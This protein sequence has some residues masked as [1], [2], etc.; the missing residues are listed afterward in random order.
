MEPC[1]GIANSGFHRYIYGIMAL[2]PLRYVDVTQ[3]DHEGQA[4]VCLRDPEGIVDEPVLLSPAGFFIASQLDGE[5]ESADIQRAFA[6][7]TGGR[8][9]RDGDV[10]HVVSFLDDHGFLLTPSFLE[11]R[12]AV[13]KTFRDSDTRAA[14]LAG[15]SYPA[16]PVELRAYLNDMFTREKGPGEAP[17]SP[18]LDGAPLR[19]L[20]VPHIDFERG[21]HTYAHGFARM[22]RAGRPETVVIFGVAHAGPPVP[23]VMTRKGFETPFGTL[24]TD[25]DLIDRIDPACKPD[26]FEHEIVH[27]TEHSIEFQ[28]VMLAYLY[29]PNVKIVPILCGPFLSER[30]G[31]APDVDGT[32]RE[33]LDRCQ[34][35]LAESGKRITVIASADL[36]HV[37]RTFGDDFEVNDA[38]ID[39]VRARDAADLEYVAAMNPEEWYQ[40]VMIDENQRRVC[41]LNCIYSTMKCVEGAVTIGELVH[42]DYAPD[43]SGGIV[44]FA[45]LVLA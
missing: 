41:G 32:V 5:S 10:D 24:E 11:R 6:E 36:A 25:L 9:L 16:D 17:L 21:G 13:H 42:Y 38:V 18:C 31:L 30:E 20:V 12:D 3:I 4:L 8:V 7:S 1:N 37:G 43:P 29:G 39:Q 40:A 33:F 23:F 15:K 34:T 2:P 19:G 45:G 35:V 28:A 22:A 14:Y 27:R 44:S 26:P